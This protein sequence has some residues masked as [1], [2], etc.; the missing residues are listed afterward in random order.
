[1]SNLIGSLGNMAKPAGVRLPALLQ[2]HQHSR[3]PSIAD[4]PI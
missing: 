3:V 4:S 1:M 2:N